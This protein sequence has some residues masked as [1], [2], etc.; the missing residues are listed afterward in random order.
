MKISLR[1][2]C[3]IGVC[4]GAAHSF[5]IDLM[6]VP[7]NPSAQSDQ[8]GAVLLQSKQVHEVAVR[9]QTGRFTGEF[10]KLPQFV[11]GFANGGETAI[12][13][14]PD[15][16]TAFSG[17]QLVRIYTV[18]EMTKKLEAKLKAQIKIQR[19]L[20]SGSIYPV[21]NYSA[22]TFN[23]AM[24]AAR[25]LPIKTPDNDIGAMLKLQ[26]VVPSAMAAGLVKLYPEDIN[27]GE[28]L[29]L[30]IAV[31]GEIHEFIFTVTQTSP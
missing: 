1:V 14:S 12:D 3:L 4:C 30:V 19:Q 28:P 16:I 31:G 9:L 25:A 15:N 8:G 2:L 7:V 24:E 10:D 29:K 6:M 26:T 22:S 18:A 11:V 23:P 5:A 13:F 27:V 21:G 20:S 17:E